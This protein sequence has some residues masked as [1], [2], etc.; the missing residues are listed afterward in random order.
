MLTD[1]DITKYCDL[2][3]KRSGKDIDREQAREDLLGLVRLVSLVH[4]AKNNEI[5]YEE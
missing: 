5:N 1:A 2:Y 3:K 4:S